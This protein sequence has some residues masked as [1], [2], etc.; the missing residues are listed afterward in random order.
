MF[1]K[2]LGV[3]AK[4][5]LCLL[6]ALPFQPMFLV[7]LCHLVPFRHVLY[8]VPLLRDSLIKPLSPLCS[9]CYHPG[10]SVTPLSRLVSLLE[11]PFPY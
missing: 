7:L 11:G 5:G 8:P 10:K 6:P 2:A 9:A 1:K 4:L 3:C